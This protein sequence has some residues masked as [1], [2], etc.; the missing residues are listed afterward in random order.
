MSPN[1]EVILPQEKLA[2]AESLIIANPEIVGFQ[3][4]EY[5][6]NNSNNF[7]DRFVSGDKGAL[8]EIEYPLLNGEQLLILADRAK[9]S[10]VALMAGEDNAKTKGLYNAIEYRLS[11]MFLIDLSCQLINTDINN[12]EQDDLNK[13]YRETSEALYGK[14]DKDVFSSLANK[15][16]SPLLN[17]DYDSGTSEESIKEQLHDLFGS[18]DESDYQ[19]YS[20]KPE[21]LSVLGSLLHDRFDEILSHI[22]ENIEYSA[23]DMVTAISQVMKNILGDNHEWNV[24][25]KQN[26][27]ILSTSPHRKLIEIGENKKALNGLDLKAL[28]LHECGVHAL[29]S[30]NANDAGWL[31]AAYGQ[32]GYLAFE[33][34]LATAMQDAYIGK[35]KDHGINYYLIAGLAYGMDNHMERDFAEIYEI[36]WRY[37]SLSAASDTELTDEI[38]NISK[39]K[40]FNAC[41]RMFRG[42]KLDNGA[43]YLKDLAYFVGQEKAWSLLDNTKTQN[44]LNLLLAGK[45]DLTIAEHMDIAQQIING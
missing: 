45:L 19:Q 44:D 39:T 26:S 4:Y 35:F 36:M 30:V 11:E 3:G 43:L 25:L 5:L 42:T 9:E 37:N 2:N 33:E 12:S 27:G 21:T 18:F 15:Y 17:K 24:L 10:L 32:E 7:R 38:I 29:R 1:K 22:D 13:W 6:V 41:M 31:S 16:V 23:E 40:A 8:Y 28:A 20:P 14:P 34:A